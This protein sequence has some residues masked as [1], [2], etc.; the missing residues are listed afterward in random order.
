MVGSHAVFLRKVEHWLTQS[1]PAKL[2]PGYEYK[3]IITHGKPASYRVMD[4]FV[5]VITGNVLVTVYANA[6]KEVELV[7]K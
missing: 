4:G 7:K 3:K 6:A 1:R 5:L 2:K